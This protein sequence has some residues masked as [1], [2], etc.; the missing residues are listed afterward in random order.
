MIHN[1][2]TNT[3]P[4]ICH[5]P[6]RSYRKGYA[7]VV[8]EQMLSSHVQDI[9]IPN[10][11][12]VLSF[13]TCDEN[14]LLESQLNHNNSFYSHKICLNKKW[15]HIYRIEILVDYI[16]QLAHQYIL[17]LDAYDVLLNQ[18]NLSDMVNY[19]DDEKI[20][21]NAEKHFYNTIDDETLK[22]KIKST[23]DTYN[24]QYIYKYLNAGCF[25]GPKNITLDFFKTLL[26]L[27]KDNTTKF[28]KLKCDQTAIQLYWHL[29]KDKNFGNIIN[30]D[31]RC[32]IFMCMNYLRPSEISVL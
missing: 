15:Q 1:V 28:S 5:F 3:K 24:Y 4:F 30:I 2:I 13:K 23:F 20:I 18:S 12:A 19:I 25:V 9:Y 16:S 26:S 11:L 27:V 31:S 6:G 29:S 17:H 8:F 21:F 7:K 14:S 22:E 10:N 32:N